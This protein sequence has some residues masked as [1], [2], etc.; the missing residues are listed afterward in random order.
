MSNKKLVED[1]HLCES[2]IESLG[3]EL[4]AIYERVRADLGEKDAQYIYGMIRLQRTLEVV[5]R[6]ALVLAASRNRWG[7]FISASALGAAKILENMEVGHNILHGQWDWMNDPEVSSATYEW[8]FDD[9]SE[10]WKQSHNLVHHKYTNIMGVDE[11]FGFGLLRL[12]PERNWKPIHLG[13]LPFN[14]FFTL[15]FATGVAFR[16]LQLVAINRGRDVDD[17]F[18]G[19]LNTVQR[20][21]I[22]LYAKDYVLYPAL[23]SRG[24]FKGWRRA[25][26]AVLAAN[27]ARNSWV[28]SLQMGNHW[29]ASVVKFR[30]SDIE[31]ETRSEWYVRQIVGSANFHSGTFFRIFSGHLTHQIEHHLFPDLPSSRYAEIAPEVQ[32]LCQK[33][34]IPYTIDSFPRQW[35]RVWGLLAKMSLPPAIAPQSINR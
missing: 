27:I 33:Y 2:D 15:I 3:A 4:T 12:T 21:I 1:L 10:L 28:Y 23:A 17:T 31:D 13:N 18:Q 9:P 11:D 8:D 19:K 6:L 14:L 34:D 5:S 35:L 16:N 25:A 32:E 20:K 7:W 22:K 24:S 26:S 30:K 29:P